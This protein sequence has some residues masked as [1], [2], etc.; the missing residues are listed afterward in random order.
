MGTV[1]HEFDAIAMTPLQV[2]PVQQQLAMASLGEAAS[3]RCDW[4]NRLENLPPEFEHGSL[5]LGIIQT[6]EGNEAVCL[7]PQH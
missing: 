7:G 5:V 1:R 2:Q 4:L 3:H 6:A